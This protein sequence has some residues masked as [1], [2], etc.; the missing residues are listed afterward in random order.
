MKAVWRITLLALVLAVLLPTMAAAKECEFEFY[1]QK[2]E[3]VKQINNPNPQGWWEKTKAAVKGAGNWVARQWEKGVTRNFFPGSGEKTWYSEEDPNTAYTVKRVK[4][5]TEAELMAQMGAKAEYELSD[6]QKAL[7]EIFRHSKSQAIKDRMQYSFRSKVKVLLT[8]TTGFEDESKYPNITKDFWPYSSG[9]AISMNSKRYNYPDGAEDAKSTFVHEFAHT[10]DLTMQ[11][12]NGYGPDG[13]HYSNEKTKP[14][15]A[16][17]EGFAEFNQALDDPSEAVRYR[18]RNKTIMV[19]KSKGEYDHVDATKLSGKDL[20]SVEG[21]NA[22]IMYRMAT[23]IDGGRDKV[24][25]AFK[26]SNWPWRSIKQFLHSATKNNPADIEKIALILDSET[27]GK[28]SDA[29]MKNYL[30]DSDA[31]KAYLAKRK[32]IKSGTASTTA[33]TGTL[34]PVTVEGTNP[35]GK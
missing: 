11:E 30:G 19:E 32:E 22:M 14:R 15:A 16:F 20:L 4:V 10:L 28:L 1:Y 24:F 18:N 27:L 5:S 35:F 23:E 21:I 7:L 2:I 17:L 3:A 33:G 25:K 9:F 34:V 6:G 8:D 29:E 12:M 13:T 31:L 26:D